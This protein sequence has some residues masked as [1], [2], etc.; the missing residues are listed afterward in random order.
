MFT[1]G[2]SISSSSLKVRH[3]FLSMRSNPNVK[4]CPHKVGHLEFL[5]IVREVIGIEEK[6]END[7]VEV[8]PYRWGAEIHG[9][10][11]LFPA[12]AK[13]EHSLAFSHSVDRRLTTALYL[14]WEQLGDWT[15][16][17]GSIITDSI[18]IP[19]TTGVSSKE[20]GEEIRQAT[21]SL[22]RRARS[23]SH[24]M[25]I[26][27]AADHM[28]SVEEAKNIVLGWLGEGAIPDSRGVRMIRQIE[29]TYNHAL[30]PPAKQG[31]ISHLDL[32]LILSRYM[33]MSSLP[34]QF[35]SLCYAWSQL[36]KRR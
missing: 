2:R 3:N 34:A 8:C 14:S 13:E 12:G 23:T 18:R 22:I 25:E 16:V 11:G 20:Q 7:P 5:Q 1:N 4:T 21:K 28:I 26:R 35:T 31:K 9:S 30:L 29:F 19:V 6:E 24:R 15:K 32:L 27:Q 36:T 10:V 33:K 17:G